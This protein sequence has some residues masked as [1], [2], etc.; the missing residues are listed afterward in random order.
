V[1]KTRVQ[2][3]PPQPKK[4]PSL[5]P[6]YE[7]HLDFA[8]YT[9]RQR[10]KEHLLQEFTE[11]GQ[12]FSQ[13]AHDGHSN[14]YESIKASMMDLDEGEMAILRDSFVGPDIGQ[15]SLRNQPSTDFHKTEK[16]GHDDGFDKNNKVK[17]ILSA[18]KQNIDDPNFIGTLFELI[19]HGPY[20]PSFAQTLPNRNENPVTEPKVARPSSKNS[21]TEAPKKP[22]FRITSANSTSKESTQ[23]LDTPNQ[24]LKDQ[25]ISEKSSTKLFPPKTKRSVEI[26]KFSQVEDEFLDSIE[27]ANQFHKQS[28]PKYINNDSKKVQGDLNL[29][30]FIDEEQQSKPNP[31]NTYQQQVK[32]ETAKVEKPQDPKHKPAEVAKSTRPGPS[33]TTKVA[34]SLFESGIDG[35]NPLVSIQSHNTLVIRIKSSI[36]GDCKEIGLTRVMLFDVAGKEIP[37]LPKDVSIAGCSPSL[38]Q[39][40]VTADPCSAKPNDLFKMEFPLLSSFIDLKFKYY[41]PDPGFLRIWNYFPDKAVGCKEIEV[42]VNKAGSVEFKLG[43]ALYSKSGDYYQ[44]IRLSTEAVMDDKKP[45]KIIPEEKNIKEEIVSSRNYDLLFGDDGEH[46][47]S[48]S[49]TSLGGRSRRKAQEPN[50]QITVKKSAQQSQTLDSGLANRRD[51]GII[52]HQNVGNLDLELDEVVPKEISRRRESN[53]K[54]QVGDYRSRRDEM[55]QKHKIMEPTID[56]ISDFVKAQVHKDN[57]VIAAMNSDPFTQDNLPIGD[58]QVVKLDLEESL[59]IPKDENFKK[60]KPGLRKEDAMDALEMQLNN[61]RKFEKKNMSRIELSGL[62]LS[63]L[64]A[65]TTVLNNQV[66]SKPVNWTKKPAEAKPFEAQEMFTYSSFSDLL[67]QNDMFFVPELPKGRIL[68]FDFYSTWGDKFY[69]GLCGI[70]VFDGEGKPVQIERSAVS[71]DPPNL[72]VLPETSGDPRTV[73]KLVD[74]VYNTTD[75]LHCWLAPLAT[76]KPNRVR[77]D[78]GRKC[79]ISLIRIWNYNK[80]RVHTARGVR[81]FALKLDGALLVFGELAKAGGEAADPGAN[82]EWLVFCRQELFVQIEA[83]DWLHKQKR[84]D[85]PTSAVEGW[86]NRPNTSSGKE[87]L[88]ENPRLKDITDIKRQLEIEKQKLIEL[89]KETQERKKLK[90]AAQKTTTFI[91]CIKLSINI[92][93]NWGDSNFVG[94]TGIEFYDENKQVIRLTADCI[95]AK[96]RDLKTELQNNDKRILENLINGDNQSCEPFDMWLTQFSKHVKP[97]LYVNFGE[98]KKISGMRVWNYNQN[99]QDSFRGAKRIEIMADLNKI[100]SNFVHLKKAPGR[101]DVDFSQFIPFPPPKSKQMFKADPEKLEKFVQLSLP[102]KQPSGFCL[103]FHLL[104]TWGDSYY[105][106]LNRI[107][108]YDRQGKPLL[109][110]GQAG[111][112]IIAVPADI[113]ILPGVNSDSRTADNLAGDRGKGATAGRGWLAPFI[114]PHVTS[115]ANLGFERNELFV[116]FQEHVSISCISFWNYSKT[117]SRGVKEIE[118]SIDECSIYSVIPTLTRVN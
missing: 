85:K 47:G 24:N 50:V 28:H 91:E 106:G 58:S 69:I 29:D 12:N 27:Q 74:G 37:L 30:F 10:D 17:A 51:E 35:G 21:V 70:E 61:L 55:K 114:N 53:S 75:D 16:S 94:L 65:K 72:N 112:K 97:Y 96:P 76:S 56:N 38:A 93:E 109:S 64:P 39:K 3:L 73:D 92:V 98:K 11:T 62:D 117:P 5:K 87:E 25:S 22:N 14:A 111:A 118:I 40:L 1:D 105:I 80:D 4:T 15:D 88:A 18:I 9:I 48:P 41:G 108:I 23:R 60:T 101:D 102:P 68:D 19:K 45:P 113:N 52:P 13:G 57:H 71:A 54:N 90:E 99:E 100:T 46:Q 34:D 42:L 115:K 59:I 63:Q 78:L 8:K 86:Q 84:S 43:P 110:S 83:H 2:A 107:E 36:G 89:E 20:K 31:V 6:I 103:R 81:E 49:K 67:N 77:L 32:K 33:A 7:D 95:N 66:I 116:I 26:A 44:D 79:V 82:A 104:S